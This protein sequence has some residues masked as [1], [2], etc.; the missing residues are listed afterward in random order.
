MHT[1]ICGC[2]VRAQS[3][4]IVSQRRVC[5]W[6]TAGL[7]SFTQDT[8]VMNSTGH[9]RRLIIFINSRWPRNSI[10]DLHIFHKADSKFSMRSLGVGLNYAT[11]LRSY[12][13]Q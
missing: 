6:L 13:S 1:W 11:V 3:P 9:P 4:R 7:R 12:I 2:A 10:H 5:D 8:T